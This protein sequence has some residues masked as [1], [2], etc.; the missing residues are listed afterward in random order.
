MTADISTAAVGLLVLDERV[1]PRAVIS[2]ER[3]TRLADALR[4]GTQLP[5]I[6]ADTATRRVVDGFHRCHAHLRVH[7]PDAE[8]EVEWRRYRSD[9]DLFADA[10]RINAAHG[11]PLSGIDIAHCLAVARQL[12]VPDDDMPRVLSLAEDKLRKMRG[13]RFA[14]DENGQQVLLK[15][16]NRH[17][18]G[19]TLTRT[20]IAGNQQASGMNLGFH[21]NQIINALETDIADLRQPGLPVAL[22][23]LRAL[24][25]EALGDE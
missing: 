16:S 23:K 22:R 20:Q 9:A 13:E 2:H 24:I 5:P 21:A 15:R 25:T 17:L 12:G 3:I 11:Q 10:A 8:T 19:R 14:S 1:Y 18:A 4:S 7:G 6:I